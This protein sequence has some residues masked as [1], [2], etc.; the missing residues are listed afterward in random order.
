MPWSIRNV[1][2]EEDGGMARRCRREVLYLL[3][4]NC[5]TLRPQVE[6]VEEEMTSR[7]MELVLVSS[8]KKITGE[9][10]RGCEPVRPS[11]GGILADRSSQK[12]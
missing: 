12:H 11:G 9:V 7:A 3:S 6:A 5:C 10:E 1:E 2:N 4:H 8:P